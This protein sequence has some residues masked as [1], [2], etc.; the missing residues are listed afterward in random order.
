VT[1]NPDAEA[2][3][4]SLDAGDAFGLPPSATSPLIG[5]M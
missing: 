4:R 3:A 2:I 1:N 5:N